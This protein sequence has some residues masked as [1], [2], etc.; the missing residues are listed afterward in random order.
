MNRN[1]KTLSGGEAQKVMLARAVVQQTN[2]LLL[3]EPTASLDLGSQVDMLAF[4]SQYAQRHNVVVLMVSHD[5]NAALRF[6]SQFVLIDPKGNVSTVAAQDLTEA[7]LRR[8]YGVDV[9]LHEIDGQRFALV[10]GKAHHFQQRV[11]NV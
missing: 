1:A 4:V 6:C 9:R 7:D 2:V 11:G 3:D 8:T 10:E 5:I